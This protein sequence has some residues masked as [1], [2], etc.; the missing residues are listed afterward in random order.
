MGNGLDPP[1]LECLNLA[2]GTRITSWAN[3]FCSASTNSLLQGMWRAKPS[4]EHLRT[5]LRAAQG[6]GRDQSKGAQRAFPF[7]SFV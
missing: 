1:G 7:N 4:G 6:E 5:A 3:S 2:V